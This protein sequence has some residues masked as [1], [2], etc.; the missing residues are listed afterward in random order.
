M[1]VAFSMRVC[2]LRG[3]LVGVCSFVRV[4]IDSLG[5][6]WSMELTVDI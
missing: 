5:G 2:T 3:A 4:I 1:V 6:F